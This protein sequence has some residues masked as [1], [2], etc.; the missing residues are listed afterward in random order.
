[1]EKVKEHNSILEM[2]K[3]N[4]TIHYETLDVNKLKGII[5]SLLTNNRNVNT[6]IVDTG[7]GIIELYEVYNGFFDHG[8]YLSVVTITITPD[9]KKISIISKTYYQ[10]GD[11]ISYYGLAQLC[12]AAII[13][14]I[15]N[16][17]PYFFMNTSST[18]DEVKHINYTESQMHQLQI[19]L[20]HVEEANIKYIQD[21]YYSDTS[22]WEE[23]KAD[24]SKHVK[25]HHSFKNGSV[26]DTL[27][28]A[29]LYPIVSLA[30]QEDKRDQDTS[31][32][33]A[34]LVKNYFDIDD[35]IVYHG[36]S[37]KYIVEKAN[38][39]GFIDMAK[40]LEI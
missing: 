6:Y 31:I 26:L 2:L 14:Y 21:T 8:S 3:V 37:L 29:E 16:H 24:I 1:M 25:L 22:K 32:V 15:K 38:E 11:D 17:D 18:K 9:E 39:Y 10:V 5:P 13:Q 27:F 28:I 36:N 19:M 33:P 23:F 20:N 12:H 30:V 40:R 34:I 35:H 4:T 7:M